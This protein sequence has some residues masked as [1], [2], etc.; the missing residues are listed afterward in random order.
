MT[1]ARMGNMARA[2]VEVTIDMIMDC[3]QEFSYLKETLEGKVKYMELKQLF[4]F[5]YAT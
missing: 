4:S 3:I 5:K 2:M 1:M